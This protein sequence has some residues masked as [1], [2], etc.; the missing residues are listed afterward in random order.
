MSCIH[1]V[2]WIRQ[3]SSVK[4]N[5]CNLIK[6]SIWIYSYTR[7]LKKTAQQIVILECLPSMCLSFTI[8]IILQATTIPCKHCLKCSYVQRKSIHS[9]QKGKNPALL[10]K[11][12]VNETENA[13]MLSC[14]TFSHFWVFFNLIITFQKTHI[15]IRKDRGRQWDTRS[16]EEFVY[17]DTPNKFCGPR[18]YKLILSASFHPNMN[19]T[20]SSNHWLLTIPHNKRTSRRSRTTKISRNLDESTSYTSTG[21][22]SSRQSYTAD[23][24]GTVRPGRKPSSTFLSISYAFPWSP[25]MALVKQER[26]NL[27]M[28]QHGCFSDVF[29]L[30]KFGR[31]GMYTN[32]P[33]I[34]PCYTQL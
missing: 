7:V 26:P 20:G 3:M 29:T 4:R 9:I 5:S 13:I 12:I 25:L 16:I 24:Q 33:L 23:S 21:A 31:T 27:D 8:L 18:D 15:A 1:C 34:F 14:R 2:N 30:Q 28:T 10:R 17:D 11:G 32:K 19:Y 22:P 6:R